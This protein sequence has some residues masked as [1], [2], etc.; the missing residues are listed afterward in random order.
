MADIKDNKPYIITIGTDN[1]PGGVEGE[2]HVKF[3]PDIMTVTFGEQEE[4]AKEFG[5]TM[6]VTNG[7]EWADFYREDEAVKFAEKVV[8]MNQERELQARFDAFKAKHGEEPLYAE[9]TIRWKDDGTEQEDIIKLSDDIDERDD[10]KVFFNV[11]GLNDLKSLINPDNGEDFY[12]FDVQNIIFQPKSLFLNDEKAVTVEQIQEKA[13]KL[14]GNNFEFDYWNETQAGTKIDRIDLGE[15][16]DTISIDKLEIKDGKLSLYSND[17]ASDVDL[18]ALDDIELSK[19]DVS[20]EEIKSFLDVKTLLTGVNDKLRNLL[21]DYGDHIFI[22]E[23]LAIQ[24]P[25]K[26][27]RVFEVTHSLLVDT[28][29]DVFVCGTT[30]GGFRL[31]NLTSDE[32][33]KLNNILNEKKYNIFLSSNKEKDIVGRYQA[34]GMGNGTQLWPDRGTL[35]AYQAYAFKDNKILVFKDAD[36][37]KGVLLSSLPHEEQKYIMDSIGSLLDRH[38]ITQE[39]NFAE[40]REHLMSVLDSARSDLGDTI[41][42]KPTTVKVSGIKT[43]AKAVFL[44]PDGKG[45]GEFRLAGEGYSVLATGKDGHTEFDVSKI[46]DDASSVNGLMKAVHDVHV[47]HLEGLA[48]HAIH[49]RITNAWQ[50]FFTP[51]QLK[52][53]NRYYQVSASDNTAREVFSHLLDEVKQEPDVIRKPEK[54]ITDTAKELNDL[55]EGITRDEARGLHK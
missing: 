34:A 18:Q 6:R 49:D 50:R 55:A 35:G 25:D 9:V 44:A 4:V 21:P 42:I 28:N 32:L 1:R 15:M 46:L 38:L 11:T 19:V 37:N 2:Y 40:A 17:I 7:Q 53:L 41:L 22:N 30:N 5:G 36:D 12:I 3:K 31:E 51:D 52:I 39:K 48:K 29:E 23:D 54:W 26:T 10:D 16:P 14:F 47:A 43:P 8:G 13:V 45:G 20:L 24:R 33:Q 27:I